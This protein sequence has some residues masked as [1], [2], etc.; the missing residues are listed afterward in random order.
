MGHGGD[1]HR[2]VSDQDLAHPVGDNGQP[3]SNECEVVP[4]ETQGVIGT[5]SLGRASEKARYSNYGSGMADVSAPSTTA[6]P[7]TARRRC[8]RPPPAAY[9]SA[10]R[11]RRWRRRMR[12]ASLP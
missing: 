8:C 3:I 4:A 11:A 5:V 6:R 2:D 1:I 7:A 10:F 12:Q 9:T